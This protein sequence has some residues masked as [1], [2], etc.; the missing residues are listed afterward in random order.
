MIRTVTSIV[1]L[2]LAA[3]PLN[4]QAPSGQPERLVKEFHDALALGDSGKVLALL[5]ENVV[6]FEGGRTEASRAEYQSHH[7]GADMELAASTTRNVED[8]WTGG[9]QDVAW[10]LTRARTTGSFRGRE[11]DLHGTE[12]IVLRRIA[13]GWRITHIHWSSRPGN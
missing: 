5:A 2:G 12:T 3:L 9:N 10:V 1:C 6:I 13:G 7:L 8:R 4:A 11:I